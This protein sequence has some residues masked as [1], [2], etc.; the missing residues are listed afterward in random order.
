MTQHSEAPWKHY[1]DSEAA[2]HRHVIAAMGKT[3]AHIYCTKGREAEDAANARLIAA[4]PDML[5][6][7]ELII[8]ATREG[9]LDEDRKEEL[10]VGFRA[11]RA[12][13]AKAKVS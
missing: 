3:V 10:N 1:D 11:A 9:P 8:A 5:S 6:A 12:A 7:L 2:T 4:A 13:I